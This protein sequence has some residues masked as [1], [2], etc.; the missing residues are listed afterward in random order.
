MGIF[1]VYVSFREG[2][3]KNCWLDFCWRTSSHWCYHDPAIFSLIFQEPQGFLSPTAFL[4]YQL[5]LSSWKEHTQNHLSVQD[6]DSLNF[7][8]KY[9]QAKRYHV[10]TGTCLLWLVEGWLSP[11]P[12]FTQRW[13][14]WDG[15][16][17]PV[18]LA[19]SQCRHLLQDFKELSP[20]KS[21]WPQVATLPL[22]EIRANAL[23]QRPSTGSEAKSFRLLVKHHYNDWKAD[24]D[25]V[26]KMYMTS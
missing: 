7:L 4:T 24:Y 20:P 1:M 16:P 11:A 6:S 8:E 18:V 23:A 3:S 19:C 26:L 5:H 13:I 15:P 10:G 12:N 14:W 21:G 25:M 9:V 22:R 2:K 17:T